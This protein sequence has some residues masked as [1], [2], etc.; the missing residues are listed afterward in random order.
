[1]PSLNARGKMNLPR[2]T[3]FLWVLA[4]VSLQASVPDGFRYFNFL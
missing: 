4:L 2:T 1:M 3:R